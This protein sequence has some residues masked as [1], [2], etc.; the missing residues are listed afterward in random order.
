[1]IGDVGNGV[2]T[3]RYIFDI[4]L[5]DFDRHLFTAAEREAH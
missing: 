1:M 3:Y 4:V 5:R 2:L